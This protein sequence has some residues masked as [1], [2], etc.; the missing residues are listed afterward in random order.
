MVTFSLF[1]HTSLKAA[2]SACTWTGALLLNLNFFKKNNISKS[3]NSSK[4]FWNYHGKVEISSPTSTKFHSWASNIKTFV[5]MRA[6]S[7]LILNS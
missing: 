7:D 3:D 1:Q 5:Q 4:L 6:N 2:R